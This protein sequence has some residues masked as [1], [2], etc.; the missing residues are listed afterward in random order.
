MAFVIK[1]RALSISRP[2]L[3]RA[4]PVESVKPRAFC[5]NS[6][7][8]LRF[9]SGLIG[10]SSNIP[11]S[12]AL[13][14]S[15]GEAFAPKNSVGLKMISCSRIVC[16]EL[17]SDEEPS[18]PSSPDNIEYNGSSLEEAGFDLRL[19]R[20][21]LMVQFTCDACGVRSQRIINRVAYERGTVFLQ[22]SG[23]EQ[24]H[25]FVDNLGLVVEYDF[26]MDAESENQQD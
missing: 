6:Y 23:C 15:Y 7:Q 26:R 12:S 22:C 16:S 3:N 4:A 1:P 13:K 25:K 10:L 5:P 20:R 11:K 2:S 8:S 21:S 9:S 17:S 19:P 14:V 24:Y 18:S